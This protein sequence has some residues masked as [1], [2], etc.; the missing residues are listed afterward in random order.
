MKEICMSRDG[1]KEYTVEEIAKALTSLNSVEDG[2]ING[3][4]AAVTYFLHIDDEG[5][6]LVM[7]NHSLF[8]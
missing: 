5:N 4:G 6:I 8:I 2:D 1:R 3:Q 7:C